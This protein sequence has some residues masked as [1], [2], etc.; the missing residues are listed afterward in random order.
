MKSHDV[1]QLDAFGPPASI[2]AVVSDDL[3]RSQP[4]LMAALGLAQTVAG[5][6]DKQLYGPLGI[7]HAQW[8]RIKGGSANFPLNKLDEF[9]TLVGNNIP[10]QWL[11]FKRGFELRPL[12]SDL[13]RRV[14]ELEAE[15]AL[16]R[17]DK[18]VIVRFLKDA[19]R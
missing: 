14:A 1:T 17:R 5:L 4:T 6:D 19:G 15:L 8:S 16:E 13:E 9:M 3:V 18:E 12:R 11:S 2:P 7:D 10:L